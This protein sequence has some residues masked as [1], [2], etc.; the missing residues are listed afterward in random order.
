M[1]ITPTDP[2]WIGAW[3]LGFV[4]LGSMSILSGI[5]LFF[6]PKRL[7]P[8]VD[9]VTDENVKFINIIKGKLTI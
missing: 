8:K 9:T 7:K 4:V 6:F 2:R 3:W 1:T 5:P